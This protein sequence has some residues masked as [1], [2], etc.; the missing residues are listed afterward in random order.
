LDHDE[1]LFGPSRSFQLVFVP[2]ISQ[3]VLHTKDL[4][5]TNLV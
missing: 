5:V 1:L 4:L 2:K 3:V